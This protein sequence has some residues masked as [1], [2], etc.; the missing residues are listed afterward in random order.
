MRFSVHGFQAAQHTVAA[1][2]QCAD[3]KNTG[4]Q[5]LRVVG[6]V[7][8]GVGPGERV[9]Q[10]SQLGSGGVALLQFGA[11]QFLLHHHYTSRVKCPVYQA[12]I[13]YAEGRFF[14]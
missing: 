5:Q 7:E 3:F 1:R 12:V 13:V 4:F 14:N 2:A 8:Y 11:P 9:A 6:A 10:R